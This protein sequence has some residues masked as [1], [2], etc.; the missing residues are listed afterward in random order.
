MSFLEWFRIIQHRRASPVFALPPFHDSAWLL[1]NYR[2]CQEASDLLFH[3]NLLYSTSRLATS[4][5]LLHCCLDADA[6]TFRRF[7]SAHV[8]I[9]IYIHV[10]TYLLMCA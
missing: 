6:R 5:K 9:Y 2:C 4:L 8:Y 7:P 3:V 1:F 10:Y